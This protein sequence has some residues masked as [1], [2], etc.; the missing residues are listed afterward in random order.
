MFDNEIE[1]C[2][3]CGLPSDECIC[4][5]I[6]KEEQRIKVSV[7]QRKW[8]KPYTII[9]GLSAKDIDLKEL[10][11]KLKSKLACGGTVKDSVIELQGDH[12]YR[13]IPILEELG[14]N[15]DKI[16]LIG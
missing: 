9:T 1:I 8:K 11:M 2:T 13:V 14:F 15:R 3:V 12:R 4:E 5:S 7:E 10:T 6:S 16:D